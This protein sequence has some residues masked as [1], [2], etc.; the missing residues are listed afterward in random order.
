M[1]NVLQAHIAE[2]KDQLTKAEAEVIRLREHVNE[3]TRRAHWHLLKQLD[4]AEQKTRAEWWLY[5]KAPHGLK[6]EP[7]TVELRKFRYENRGDW[8]Y[9]LRITDPD[10]LA[11]YIEAF[12]NA[13]EG[14]YT[15]D[16]FRGMP[17][18]YRF[19]RVPGFNKIYYNM[20][21]KKAEPETPV[22]CE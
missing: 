19:G 12:T 10:E 18:Y 3:V 20:R 15:K 7:A 4:K 8:E 13:N 5:A 11:A 6:L 1:Q 2:L 14:N 16:T 9:E 17:L 22:A 21:P